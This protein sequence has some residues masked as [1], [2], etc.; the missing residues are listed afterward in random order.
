M[1]TIGIVAIDLM[2]ISNFD[3]YSLALETERIGNETIGQMGRQREQLQNANSNL[4]ATL[5]VARQAGV[6]LTDMYVFVCG[7][8]RGKY[9]SD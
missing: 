3:Y 9:L 1:T 7:N 8:D 6:I 4:D 2:K 5:D